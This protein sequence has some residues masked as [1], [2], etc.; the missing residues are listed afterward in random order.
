MSPAFNAKAQGRG[1]AK[2]TKPCPVPG[3]PAER[4]GT[5]LMCLTH[6]RLV[7]ISIQREVWSY[8]RNRNMAEYW[9]ARSRAI[10]AAAAAELAKRNLNSGGPQAEL[11]I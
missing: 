9:P 10:D 4:E 11:K 7:P 5:K 2:E 1:G 3:C 6:W 8:W